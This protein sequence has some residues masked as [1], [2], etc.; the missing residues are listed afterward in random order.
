MKDKSVM[1]SINVPHIA[2]TLLEKAGFKVTPWTK[3]RPITHEELISMA[4]K[5]HAL[6]CTMADKI[7]THFLSECSH[8]DIISQYAVGYDNINISEATK[9]GI[10][11]GFTP[12]TTNEATADIAFGLMIATSRKMFFLH[13]T[14]I[15]GKW[16]YFKPKA[17]LGIALKNKTLG[18]FGLGR[19]GI[20]MARRCI[21]AYN[22]K[23]FYHNRK[24]NIEAESKLKVHYVDFK[25]LLRESDV[26]SVHCSLNETTAGIFNASVFKQMKSSAIFINTSRGL[27][28]NEKD[29]IAALNSGEIWGAGLDVTNPEPMAPDN[30]LLAMENVSV[31]P[32]TGSGTVETRNAMA[33]MAATNIIEWYENKSTVNIVNYAGLKSNF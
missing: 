28:H 4:K 5:H 11:I 6:L 21:G 25:K 30:P 27:V 22:M 33:R 26:I 1:L 13:K 19:I 24:P 8:L 10:A 18:I 20:E 12:N 29:L 31:L 32:H 17:H 15:N 2:I 14:I 7:D 3:D 9:R 16:D 23:V